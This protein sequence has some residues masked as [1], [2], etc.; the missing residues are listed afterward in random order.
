M[1]KNVEIKARIEAD[2]FESLRQRSGEI[3]SD[4]PIKLV[5]TDTFFHSKTGRLKLREFADGSAELIYYE[6]PDIAG[7]KTSSYVRS[8]CPS[9]ATMKEALSGSNG[10]L[11]V[12]KK[13]REVFFVGQTRVHLDRV[14]GLG[15]FLELEVVLE[16]H[17]S[18]EMGEMIARKIM[19]K[20][21]IEQSQL[22]SGAYFDLLAQ[23]IA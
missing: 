20:L 21:N 9:P 15:A 2:R 6:R 23:Q 4:G 22:V 7:P 11:G 10:V 8:N 19:Q 12:V 14:E 18:A 13:D 3:A 17:E 16:E 1:A 5:Q